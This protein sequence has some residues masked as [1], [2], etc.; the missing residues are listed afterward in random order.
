MIAL[1][2][3]PM[4]HTKS[5]GLADLLSMTYPKIF[6]QQTRRNI[7]FAT[8]WLCFST[9]AAAARLPRRILGAEARR[10]CIWRLSSAMP[11]WSSS[12]SLRRPRWTRPTTT[13]VA[14]EG[15]SGRFGSV[16]GEM[17]EGVRTWAG[18]FRSLLWDA[19]WYRVR[20]VTCAAVVFLCR[21]RCAVVKSMMYM[22][23]LLDESIACGI[24]IS[25]T[26]QG[27]TCF[28]VIVVLR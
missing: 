1:V 28:W 13:A 7:P 12:W 16:S 27:H 5:I 2:S 22:S 4:H 15:F 14:L 18:D 23:F 20:V 19:E 24:D 21:K 17:T 6:A 3:S 11:P 10:H 26:L 25:N 9:A 8:L